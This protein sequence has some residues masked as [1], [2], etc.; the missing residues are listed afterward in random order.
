MDIAGT[1]HAS[2]KEKL[3]KREERDRGREARLRDKRERETQRD[4]MNRR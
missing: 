1:A 4:K 2:T 3:E